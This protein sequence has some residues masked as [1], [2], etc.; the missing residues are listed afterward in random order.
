MVSNGKE[1]YACEIDFEIGDYK[2]ITDL[3]AFPDTK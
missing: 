3:P 2:F 1:S